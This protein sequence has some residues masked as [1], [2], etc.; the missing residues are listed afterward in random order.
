ML[1]MGGG[2]GGGGA[3]DGSGGGGGGGGGPPVDDDS[4]G[5]SDTSSF[6]GVEKSSNI[7]SPSSLFCFL[8]NAGDCS[9]NE[10]SNNVS[11]S[12]PLSS[13]SSFIILLPSPSSRLLFLP[14]LDDGVLFG[15]P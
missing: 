12:R 8:S 14:T 2:G 3:M 1:V 7:P 11:T 6:F 15:V 5:G 10:K 9:A 13:S 4:E